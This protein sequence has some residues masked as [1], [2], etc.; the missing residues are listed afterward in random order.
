MSEETQ[1]K[2]LE[3]VRRH[4][5]EVL[6]CSPDEV[7]PEAHLSATLDMDSIDVIEVAT[8]LQSEYGVELEDHEVY[9]LD[10][11]QSLIDLVQAKLAKL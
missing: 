11:V 10:T 4:A 9:D 2:I 6:D 7:V 3:S 1:S 8:A 5:V